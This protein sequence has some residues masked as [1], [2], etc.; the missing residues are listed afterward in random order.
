M[1]QGYLAASFS[2]GWRLADLWNNLHAEE[3]RRRDGDA[4][5]AAEPPCTTSG[6]PEKPAS[7]VAGTSTSTPFRHHRPDH[8]ITPARPLGD[9]AGFEATLPLMDDFVQAGTT[10]G[11]AS[12]SSAPQP[13]RAEER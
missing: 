11:F 9:R 6:A 1:R 10:S 13:A 7:V 8:A 3:Q 12:E 5:D 4:L 2:P